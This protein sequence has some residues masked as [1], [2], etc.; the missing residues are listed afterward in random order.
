MIAEFAPLFQ[1][2]VPQKLELV[3]ELWDSIAAS[4][5]D[6]P[7]PDWQ[8]EELERRKAAYLK[9]PQSA[10]PWEEAKERIRRRDG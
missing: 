9:D 3:E 8:K 2:S 6:L 10:V 4:P 5:A 7:V 1:L